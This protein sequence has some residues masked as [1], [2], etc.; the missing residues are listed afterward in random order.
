MKSLLAF[1]SLFISL[2][3]TS[4]ALAASDEAI[5]RN[6]QGAEL[7]KQGKVDEAVGPLL[8]AVELNPKDPNIRLNLA[9][10]YDRQGRIEEAIVQYQKAVELNPQNSIAHNNLGILYERKGLY[11]EAIRELDKVAEIDSRSATAQKNL[12]TVK[13]NQSAS[14]ERERQIVEALRNVEAQPK[15]PRASYSLAR[16]YA[17]YGKKDQ[18]IGWLE[19]A[20]KLGFNE[21]GYLKV[22]SAMD[23]LRN[24]PDYVWLMRGR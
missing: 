17:A 23:S 18:A 15:N 22:D 5:E 14:Q 7:L 3:G 13:L 2:L 8:K 24:E 4:M 9:F 6:N 10:A 11:E 1:V 20:L 16:L 12:E 19:K 21:I